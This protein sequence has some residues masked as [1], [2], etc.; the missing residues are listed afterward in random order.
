MD[1]DMNEE[2]G[3]CEIND[4]ESDPEME[5]ACLNCGHSIE[6]HE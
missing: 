6:E 2:C 4:F 5:T 3:C 1:Q